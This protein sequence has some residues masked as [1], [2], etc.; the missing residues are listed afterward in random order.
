MKNMI[1]IVLMRSFI[2]LGE[3][4]FACILNPIYF[5]LLPTSSFYIKT[6]FITI[7]I[8][9]YICWCW[10][11]LSIFSWSWIHITLVTGI[12]AESACFARLL[13][14]EEHVET[15]S[16]QMTLKELLLEPEWSEFILIWW[17]VSIKFIRSF[18]KFSFF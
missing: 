2:W 1:R 15:F 4:I 3:V 17:F 10:G 7:T 16:I 18:L 6:F 13:Q 11:F 12:G 9:W 14:Y 8:K 5:L